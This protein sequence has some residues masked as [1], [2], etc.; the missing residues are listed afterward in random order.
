MCAIDAL[1]IAPMFGETIEI[2]SRDPVSD[3]VIRAR[4]APDGNAD[5]WPESA[6][7]V[8]G[9]I[10]GE[11]DA[12]CG[13][14]PV[15]NFFVSPAN[16]ERWLAEHPEV[17]GTVIS[18]EDAIAAGRAHAAPETH[19]PACDDVRGPARGA[20]DAGGRRVG[21]HTPGRRE[22]GSIGAGRGRIEAFV[23]RHEGG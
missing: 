17:R 15:L 21:A 12:R 5:W 7:V 13:C 19:E 8:A 1:G 18:M 9:T 3:E 4:V 23:K 10:R 6:R 20:A 16:G 11:D 22:R 14:C 2:E